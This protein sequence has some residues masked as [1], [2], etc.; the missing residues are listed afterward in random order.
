MTVTWKEQLVVVGNIFITFLDILGG[1]EMEDE[2]LTMKKVLVWGV[3]S[4]FKIRFF[5]LIFNNGRM[6]ARL[7]PKSST[8]SLRNSVFAF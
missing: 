1:K 4:K 5:Q 8:F 2:L 6:L 3:L 7:P